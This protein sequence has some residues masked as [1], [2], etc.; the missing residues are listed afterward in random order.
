MNAS[1]RLKRN[2]QYGRNV[3]VKV[4]SPSTAVPNV[5]VPYTTRDARS[6][7]LEETKI[8]YTLT[9]KAREYFERGKKT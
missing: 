6:F 9:D 5:T 8:P 7:I 3:H 2:S 1:K 4:N